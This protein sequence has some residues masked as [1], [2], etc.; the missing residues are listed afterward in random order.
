MSKRLQKI[1]RVIFLVYLNL[2]ALQ[3]MNAEDIWNRSRTTP[4]PQTATRST[5]ELVDF[6]PDSSPP[7]TPLTYVF[8]N[9][10]KDGSA[11]A[12][13]LRAYCD[14]F[15][16]NLLNDQPCNA[17]QIIKLPTE[18]KDVTEDLHIPEIIIKGI[19]EGPFVRF[20]TNFSDIVGQK[21]INEYLYDQDVRQRTTDI[22][23][24]RATSH[25][26]KKIVDSVTKKLVLR[27]L[28][29]E[30]NGGAPIN[31]QDVRICL[32]GGKLENSY[33]AHLRKD[34]NIDALFFLT[35]LNNLQKLGFLYS[36]SVIENCLSRLTT[37][38]RLDLTSAFNDILCINQR[39]LPPSALEPLTNLRS[40]DLS[41]N[42]TID[43]DALSR[44]TYLTELDLSSNFLI[45]DNALSLLTNLT[46]LALRE[47]GQ[48]TDQSISVLTKLKTLI[49][50]DE[51]P[52]ITDASV[53]RLTNLTSLNLDFI[54]GVTDHSLSLLTNLTEL[55]LENNIVI[56][57]QSVDQLTNLKYLYL[58]FNNTIDFSDLLFRFSLREL[59]FGSDP[60][61]DPD[62]PINIDVY[63]KFLK[64]F[65]RFFYSNRNKIPG[66]NFSFLKEMIKEFNTQ[67]SFNI[68][69]SNDLDAEELFTKAESL[70]DSIDYANQEQ[71]KI[72]HN[73][74]S[75]FFEK[76]ILI[77]DRGLNI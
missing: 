35:S 9:F 30:K 40:L 17:C 20:A 56:T 3:A 15:C 10:V 14:D 16:G 72:V 42:T 74:S 31:D 68:E 76:Y 46:E 49:L 6:F 2:H 64:N 23:N 26:L 50:I 43:D 48:I 13:Q 52:Q 75:V 71:Q 25:Q 39:P 21:I 11:G 47:N 19:V 69:I 66:E 4:L 7:Q 1:F 29:K 65:L 28:L 41:Y 59:S 57:N 12:P 60:D 62:F 67:H 18:T 45:T 8:H 36:N 61:E 73:Y 34:D 33:R 38:T 44:L 24:L 51:A 27:C 53:S 37:L 63:K 22:N 77:R 5:I 55:S 70:I 32:Y 54:T 58:E